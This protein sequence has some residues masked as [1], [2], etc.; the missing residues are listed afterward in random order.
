VTIYAR[1][2]VFS[3]PEGSIQ[4]S[5]YESS[6]VNAGPDPSDPGKDTGDITLFVGDLQMGPGFHF[7]MNG[8]KGQSVTPDAGVAPGCGGDGGIL[9]TP[10]FTA[11]PA[12]R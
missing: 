8:G 5:P 1:K 3:H 9:Q 4:T 12:S 2:L 10:V 11:L 6:T 7:V